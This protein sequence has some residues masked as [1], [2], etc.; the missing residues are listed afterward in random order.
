MSVIDGNTASGAGADQGGG[1]VF[2]AGGMINI[3]GN[4]TISNNI[5][6]GMAGSGGGILNDVGGTLVIE[7]TT[8]SGNTSIR[9]GGGIEDNSGAATTVSL[10]D[11]SITGNAT[12]SSLAT[13]VASISQVQ[14]ILKLQEAWFPIIPL[15]QKVA[16]FGTALAR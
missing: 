16:D 11:V 4:T 9:A 1:G 2:N 12:A 3:L 13:A 14:V 10:T 5:A 7:N 15:P 8:I 6:N